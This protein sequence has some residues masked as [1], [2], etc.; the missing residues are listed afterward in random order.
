MSPATQSVASVSL[1]QRDATVTVATLIDLFMSQYAGWDSSRPQRLRWWQVLH[2][3]SLART[4][5]IR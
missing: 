3:E 4:E 5:R 2:P 1:S